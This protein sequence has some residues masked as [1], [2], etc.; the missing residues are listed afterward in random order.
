MSAI[1]FDGISK[2]FV[3]HHERPRSLQ[4]LLRHLFRPRG[5]REQFWALRD[6]SFAV[7]PGEALGIIGANGS[8]KSTLLKLATRLL[9]P[10]AGRVVVDGRVAALL[11]LGAGFHPELT[12]RDNIYLNASILGIPRRR[13]DA[14]FGDIVA[15]A[16]LERFVDTPVKRYSSG[17]QARLGFAVA[18]H[19]DPDILL[20]VEVLAVGDLQFQERCRERIHALLAAGRTVL[21]VSHDLAAVGEF[22]TRVLWLH[23]GR[24]RALGA[25]EAVISAYRRFQRGAPADEALGAE[26][27]P[28]EAPEHG[29]R[30]GSGEIQL[31]AV[32]LLD[33]QGRPTQRFTTG[34]PLTVR[35]RYRATRRVRKPVFGIA[36]YAGGLQ[37]AGPNTRVD[38]YALDE[39]SGEGTLLYAIDALPL[40][41]GAYTLSAAVYDATELHPYD[42]HHQCYPFRVAAADGAERYGLVALQ[43]RW[44]SAGR[45]VPAVPP[46]ASAG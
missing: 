6:V 21:L 13:V 2:R 45:G 42:H 41:P 3:I 32:E 5:W 22:C 39:V 4:A 31:V 19:V 7:A 37:L 9:A 26:E 15:F 12:G 8:G 23:E 46:R 10:T 29:R 35:L 1:V 11:E 30:W 34:A 27:P 43:G 40:L 38:G 20:L 25:P 18:V 24:V 44:E 16:G 36:I 28:G 14:C 17:M 33:G